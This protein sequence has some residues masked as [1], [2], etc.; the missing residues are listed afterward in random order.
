MT[1]IAHFYGDIQSAGKGKGKIEGVCLTKII[2][3]I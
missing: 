3:Q 1:Q 2:K